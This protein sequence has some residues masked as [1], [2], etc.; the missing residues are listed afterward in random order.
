MLLNVSGI[1]PDPRKSSSIE[2][3][4]N[5]LSSVGMEVCTMSFINYNAFFRG[6]ISWIP[7]A[8]MLPLRSPH[9]SLGTTR[10]SDFECQWLGFGATPVT[11]MCP[12]CCV[13]KYQTLQS[14]I[15]KFVRDRRGWTLQSYHPHG[16]P[17]PS[18][19]DKFCEGGMEAH[20]IPL[21]L[22]T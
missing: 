3:M 5:I 11:P 8:S 21:M 12:P 18:I 2:S 15:T 16:R 1:S 4:G 7:C 20:G 9:F 6:C 14:Y 22:I 13:T 19:S 17:P 10:I